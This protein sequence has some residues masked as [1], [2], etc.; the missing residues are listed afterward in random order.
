MRPYADDDR[1][2]ARLMLHR[3]D[4]VMSWGGTYQVRDP[5]KPPHRRPDD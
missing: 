1:A 5:T 4:G 3:S 2:R